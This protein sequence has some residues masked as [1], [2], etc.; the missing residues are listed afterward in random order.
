MIL[1]RHMRAGDLWQ[2]LGPP[3][4]GHVAGSLRSPGRYHFPSTQG[5]GQKKRC[6]WETLEEEHFKTYTLRK[7]QRQVLCKYDTGYNA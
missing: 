4:S 6:L 5:N 1:L 2:A 3:P 7:T